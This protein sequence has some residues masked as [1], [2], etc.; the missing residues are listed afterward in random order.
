MKIDYRLL[1]QYILRYYKLLFLTFCKN[2][3]LDIKVWKF[4][5]LFLQQTIKKFE[6]YHR[7]IYF[8]KI[9]NENYKKQ[10]SF[11]NIEF[12]EFNKDILIEKL[13]FKHSCFYDLNRKFLLSKITYNLLDYVLY[14]RKKV[15]V[16]A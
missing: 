1:I 8:H 15:E 14:L 16:N 2:N 7:I 6:E 12:N 11:K 13:Y 5:I 10:L 3:I 4:N 9:D